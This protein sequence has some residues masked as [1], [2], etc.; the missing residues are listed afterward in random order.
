MNIFCLKLTIFLTNLFFPK[1]RPIPTGIYCYDENHTCPY[2]GRDANRPTQENGM[3]S[4]FKI[5][6]WEQPYV[7]LLWDACKECGIKRISMDELE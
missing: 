5:Y 7:S 3:C 2:W 4:L 1:Y 6:D